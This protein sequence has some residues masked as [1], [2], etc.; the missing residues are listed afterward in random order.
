MVALV[1]LSGD[2]GV[3]VLQMWVRKVEVCQAFRVRGRG[4]DE[5]CE[6]GG[7][8]RSRSDVCV[9]W[10]SHEQQKAMVGEEMVGRGQCLVRELDMET[11]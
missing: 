3:D 9:D 7:C 11:G 10:E 4:W 8:S 6:M 5:K 2:R 1:L